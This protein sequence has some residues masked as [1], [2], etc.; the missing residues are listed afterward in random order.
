VFLLVVLNGFIVFLYSLLADTF[1]NYPKGIKTTHLEKILNFNYRGDE[2][3]NAV[4][5]SMFLCFFV[6]EFRKKQSKITLANK[7][8]KKLEKKSKKYSRR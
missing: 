8:L 6:N 2:I 1:I 5:I 3:V 7:L 4:L